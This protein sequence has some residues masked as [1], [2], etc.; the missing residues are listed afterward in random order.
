[1]LQGFFRQ[2]MCGLL[3][4]F[5]SC[6][7]MK[8]LYPW[9]IGILCVTCCLSLQIIKVYRGL[10][11][12]LGLFFSLFFSIFLFFR[13]SL[14]F[15]WLLLELATLSLVPLFFVRG[16]SCKLSSLFSYLVVSGVSSGFIVRGFL[17]EDFLFF[18]LLGFFIKFG[19]FPFMGWVYTVCL[20][21]NWSVVYVFTILLKS[22]FIIICFFLKGY[23]YFF[24]IGCFLCICTLLLLCVLFWVYSYSWYHCW[25]HM[26]LSSR[27]ILVVM[28]LYQ[29]LESLLWFY[30]SYFIWG[31]F[32]ILFFYY[33][34]FLGSWE[35]ISVFLLYTFLLLTTPISFSL[36]YK[37]SVGYVVFSTSFLVFCFWVVYRLSEQFYLF[38]YLCSSFVPKKGFVWFS[39]I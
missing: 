24:E 22:S 19:L 35:G 16:E 34:R 7:F 14:V 8:S 4:Y 15:S 17:L 31:S 37:F 13:D 21:S 38:K 9:F 12:F 10:V 6:F 20:F 11:W 5:L 26:M 1:M 3:F 36:L 39:H 28:S 30:F 27:G 29:S 2:F 18:L 23:Y 33:Y 25:C 32:C